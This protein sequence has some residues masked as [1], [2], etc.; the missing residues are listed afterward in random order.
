MGRAIDYLE[1]RP[2][3]QSEKLAY[4]GVSWGAAVLQFPALEKR[5][6]TAIL[7]SG[8]LVFVETFP[9]VDSFHFAARVTVPVLMING[10]DDFVFPL[11]TSQKP[12]FRLLGATEKKHRLFDS[13]HT[14]PRNQAIK[15]ILDWLDRYLGPVE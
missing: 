13:G 4:V 9:E 11:E 6:K 12:L 7:L 10:K 15:E 8:G 3:I 1:T 5:F 14:I 2:D